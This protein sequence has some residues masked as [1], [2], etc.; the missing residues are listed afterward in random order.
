[1]NSLAPSQSYKSVYLFA[2]KINDIHSIRLNRRSTRSR[3]NF[4]QC[5]SRTL[6]CK[7][8]KL[9]LAHPFD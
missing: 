4:V 5:V 2:A 1:M 3:D 9:L 7:L 6:R 8:L